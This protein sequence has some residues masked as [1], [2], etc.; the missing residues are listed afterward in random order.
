MSHGGLFPLGVKLDKC[1]KVYPKCVVAQRLDL[2]K[3]LEALYYFLIKN[4]DEQYKL[5]F[6]TILS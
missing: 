6:E 5:S 3:L 2:L 4:S 1:E